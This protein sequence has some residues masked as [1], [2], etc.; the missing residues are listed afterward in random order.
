MESREYRKNKTT[1]LFHNLDKVIYVFSGMNFW[2]DDNNVPK[3]V[4][5]AYKRI[6]KVINV[7]IV[8]FLMAEIGSFFT[9][10]NLT[11]KQ[12]AD[13]V[14]MTFSHIILYYFTH[15]LIHRKETVTEILY[16]LAVS[17]KKDF[18]DEETERLMLKRTK[19][20]MCVFVALCCISF[21]FYGVEGLARVLFSGKAIYTI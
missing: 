9:Q 19:I 3:L 13:R 14:M 8:L 12:K 5:N 17:L 4:F 2:V 21:V 6:S 1:E 10:N 15:S 16:T 18:N 7:A 11:E 20:Y